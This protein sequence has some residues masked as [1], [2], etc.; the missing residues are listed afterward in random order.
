MPTYTFYNKNTGEEKTELMSISECEEFLKANPDW[1]QQPAAPLI[2][3]GVALGKRM[4]P[5]EGFRDLLKTIKK[6]NRGSN[7][8]T[9]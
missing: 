3:S 4:K 9:F 1:E 2:V 8:N 7:I 5:D 6:N